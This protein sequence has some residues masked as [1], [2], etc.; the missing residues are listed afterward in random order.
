MKKAFDLQHQ[1]VIELRAYTQRHTLIK[2]YFEL[3]LPQRMKPSFK[4]G[5]FCR[6]SRDNA[7]LFTADSTESL[8]PKFKI[9]P[10]KSCRVSLTFFQAILNKIASTVL[11]RAVSR[12]VPGIHT[13]WGKENSNYINYSEKLSQMK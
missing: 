5:H 2:T 1:A 7:P 12:V 4:D 13:I 9:C 11:T 8:F 6:A 10:W 3:P